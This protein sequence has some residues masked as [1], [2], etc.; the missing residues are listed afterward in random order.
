MGQ[1][2]Y[3]KFVCY[4]VNW[5]DGIFDFK[6]VGLSLKTRTSLK[7]TAE[8]RGLLPNLRRL[9]PA[10]LGQVGEVARYEWAK[11]AKS[12]LKSTAGLYIS[13]L[14]SVEVKRNIATITLHGKLPNMI[15]QGCSAYDLKVGLLKSSKVKKTKTGKPYITVPFSHTA[16]GGGNRGLLTMPRPVYRLASRLNVG[17]GGLN[18]PVKLSG[19]GIRSKLSQDLTKFGNYTWKSSPYQGMVKVQKGGRAGFT[20]FRRVSKNSDPS[21]W[22]HPGFPGIF[23]SET[24][25]NKIQNQVSII[26]E[27]ILVS[28]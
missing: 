26:A 16:P 27:R 5:L 12:K 11:A 9:V 22:I 1:L 4:F 21:S 19:Y 24:A 3:E 18:L 25:V 17:G 6:L 15:E 7:V 14:S 2:F 20:T 13:S 8:R 23:A 28:N 10:I